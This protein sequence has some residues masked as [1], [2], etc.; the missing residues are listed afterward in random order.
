MIVNQNSTNYTGGQVPAS[1]LVQLGGANKLYKFM[2]GGQDVHGQ[3]RIFGYV[4]LVNDTALVSDF[5]KDSLFNRARQDSFVVRAD[6]IIFEEAYP[7]GVAGENQNILPT[8][9]SLSQ[10]YPNPFNPTTNIRFALPSDSK[11]DLRVYDILGREVAVLM[12]GDMRPGNYT[13]TWNG[14]N[15]FN[16]QVATGMYIYRLRANNF[17]QTKKMLMIK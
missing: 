3:S 9:F 12:T 8:E 10:N 1:G 16:Q 13:I 17:V 15:G 5:Y 6:A 11:V 14:R 4:K 2:R 7:N